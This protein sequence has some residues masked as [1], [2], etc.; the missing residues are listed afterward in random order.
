MLGNSMEMFSKRVY[1]TCVVSELY[2]QRLYFILEHHG[3]S[4]NSGLLPAY[5]A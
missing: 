5:V 2:G 4:N 3:H 1:F